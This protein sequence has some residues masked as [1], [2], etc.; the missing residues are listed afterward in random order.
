MEDLN[1][2]KVVRIEKKENDNK[3]E[4]KKFNIKETCLKHILVAMTI[5]GCY[6]GN[7]RN[8][9]KICF[10]VY[11]VFIF[12]ALLAF[13]V[14]TASGFAY[15]KKSE[16]YGHA[17]VLG[18]NISGIITFL[19]TLKMNHSMFGNQERTFEFWNTTV[20]PQ[21]VDLGI[22]FD[23]LSFRRKQI[24][25]CLVATVIIA[26][27]VLG[28]VLQL[29]GI[30]GSG[31]TAM[32]TIP[33]EKTPLTCFVQVVLLIIGTFQANIPY[34][35]MI[36]ICYMLTHCFN[37]FN[38]YLDAEMSHDACRMPQTM[39]TLC[40]YYTNLCKVVADFDKDFRY[41][42]GNIF[43]WN[44]TLSLFIL[45][46]ILRVEMNNFEIIGIMAYIFWLLLSMGIVVAMSVFA[47]LVHEAAHA[48]LDNI[49]YINVQDITLEKLAQLN[50]FLSKLTGTQVGFS[51][52]GL[53]IIT[54]EFILTI[55]GVFLTYFAV[56]YI[57]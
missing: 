12:L 10:T 11:R 3:N 49:Y 13:I 23:H 2:S 7:G 19:L 28:C 40:Q 4:L 51:T 45:Y 47:A 15:I 17:V 8:C 38:Q 26:L 54:K 9:Y 1:D 36:V 46:V 39:Q 14:K 37:G 52:S 20:A 44:I 18:W 43:F 5:S 27:V 35:Y 41:L 50:L 24:I 55:A 25:L 48:P 21:M 56:L 33:F 6:N 57:L 34:F 42:L 31:N 16:Y 30:L 53:L 29:T 22:K 32:L